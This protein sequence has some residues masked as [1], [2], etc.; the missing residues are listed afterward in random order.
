MIPTH[1][2]TE[3]G[4]SRNAIINRI[5]LLFCLL[6]AALICTG[7]YSTVVENRRARRDVS[8]EL[9]KILEIAKSV[10]NSEIDKLN[11]ISSVVREQNQKFS[12]F[13][14]YERTGSITGMINTISHMHDLDLVLFFDED[15]ELLTSSRTGTRIE[16]PGQYVSLLGNGEERVGLDAVPAEVIHEQ[17]PKRV[18]FPHQKVFPA[19]KSLV[20][21]LNDTG[22]IYGF[23]ILLKLISGNQAL[24]DRMKSITGG[25]IIYFDEHGNSIVSSLPGLTVP[26][27]VKSEITLGDASYLTASQDL[28]GIGEAPIGKLTVAMNEEPFLKKRL[29]QITFNLIPFLISFTICLILFFILKARVFDKISRL[30]RALIGVSEGQGDLS[31]RLKIPRKKM[32]AG[33]LDEVEKMCLNFNHMMDK[34]ETT[35]NQLTQAQKEAEKANH[36]KSAFLANMSHEI[37]TPMN[38]VIGFSEVLLEGHLTEDQRDCATAIQ[39]SGD[40]LLSLINDILDFSKIEAGQLDFEAMDFD[41]ELLAY[42]VCDMI[43]PRIEG[44]S[45]EVLCHISDD[46]PSYVKGD[47]GRVRQVLTNLMSNAAKFTERG[48]VAL[49]LGID[50]EEEDRIKLHATIR[51]TGIGIAREKLE[52]IFEPF[53][54][55]DGSTTRKYGGTG[56]GL[57]I[58]RRIAGLMG[59]DAWAE[60]PG[61][62]GDG[63]LFHFTA[64]LLKSTVKEPEPRHSLSLAGKKVLV[65]DDNRNNRD[66]LFRDLSKAGMHVVAVDSG[67]NAL[68]ALR[69]A[70][71][72]LDPFD[73]CICDIQMPHMSGYAVARSIRREKGAFKAQERPISRLPLISLSSLMAG[74]AK[75]CKEA[76]FDGFLCKPVRKLKL[77]EMLE[78]VIE[79]RSASITDT[80]PILTQYSVRE[81]EKHSV[82]ILLAEDN[83]FNQKLAKLM[84]SKAGYSV[85]V[86]NNGMEAVERFMAGDGRLDLILMDVQMP[87]MDGLEATRRIRKLESEAK[88]AHETSHG[89][90]GSVRGRIPIVAMTAHA[91]KGDRE[92]CIEAGMDD[93]LTKPIKRERVFEMLKEWVFKREIQ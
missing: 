40:S 75:K 76:G 84:L 35:Y 70:L 81:E 50:Q 8:R 51:D 66:L 62:D 15:G 30:I 68:P 23:V 24:V 27:P 17:L 31:I 92:K 46:V 78:R 47:P 60:S 56:L 33:N 80:R 2:P 13:L 72:S 82:R 49:T 32:V 21:I 57:S 41:P 22:D 65:V 28:R 42:D 38:A 90:N 54:Q 67:A 83:P 79:G 20:R 7:V 53:S 10:Q 12:D 58:C 43:R 29:Y 63:S 1:M 37:R 5:V 44:K 55:A 87:G 59:G 36:A 11:I 61:N 48:E 77:L 39:R 64:W 88:I 34:L 45:V 71:K 4:G 69:Q 93:Y 14:D 89:E 26:E 25:Q 16:E 74:E 18:R 52:T 6:M 91:M 19:F 85:S 73:A 3:N 9:A 86:A